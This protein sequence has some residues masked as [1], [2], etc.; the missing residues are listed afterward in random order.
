MYRATTKARNAYTRIW[1]RCTGTALIFSARSSSDEY[2]SSVTRTR[3]ACSIFGYVD[4]KRTDAWAWRV[5]NF[6]LLMLESAH[7]AKTPRTRIVMDGAARNFDRGFDPR[8]LHSFSTLDTRSIVPWAVSKLQLLKSLIA[9][10]WLMI[11][12]EKLLVYFLWFI[13]YLFIHRCN[14][15]YV[16]FLVKG[17]K[18]SERNKM[19]IEMITR[20]V[21]I[22]FVLRYK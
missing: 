4:E 10:C 2:A 21:D 18:I 17:E 7:R 15:I 19:N 16:E 12:W 11:N 20:E 5:G 14:S 8:V 3:I 13:S 9:N 1:S 22:G 6:F